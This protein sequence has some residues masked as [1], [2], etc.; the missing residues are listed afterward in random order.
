MNVQVPSQDEFNALAAKVADLYSIVSSLIPKKLTLFSPTSF[1][2]QKL[3]N[4]AV[5]SVSAALVT[6]LSR[7]VAITG[8]WINTLQYSTPLYVVVDN[9]NKVPVKITNNGPQ[10]QA[11]KDYGMILRD[12]SGTVNFYAED[13][14]QYGMGQQIKSHSS[15]VV[16]SF[17]ML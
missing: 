3:A 7:N 12:K 15:T 11:V 17:G 14:T 4:P 8:P 13:T 5:S 2:N 1:W 9:I 6:E 16:Y 10:L